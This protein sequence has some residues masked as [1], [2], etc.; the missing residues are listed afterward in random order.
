MLKI[1]VIA[2]ILLVNIVIQ[3]AILPFL[4][5]VGV[6]PDTL[7]ILVISFSLLGGSGTGLTVGLTGGLIQDILYGNSVGYNAL[8]YMLIGFF[9]GA[10]HDK[11]FTD[12]IIMPSVFVFLAVLIRGVFVWVYMF[13]SNMQNPFYQ[14]FAVVVLPEAVYTTILMPLI[15]YIMSM[16]YEQKFMTKKWHFKQS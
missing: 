6:Q 16:L 13:F 9:M 11:V 5:I 4:Q 15:F 8:V 7:M 10:I 3:S 14:S 12:K 2:A 1:W